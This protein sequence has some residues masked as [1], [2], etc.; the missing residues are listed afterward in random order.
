MITKIA[1]TGMKG[2]D[3]V[4]ELG[5]Y[6]I[7][8]GPNGSGKSART[9]ALQLAVNG[10][11]PG[12]DKKNPDILKAFGTD[13]S[14]I[15]GVETEGHILE[16]HYKTN[17]KGTV[18]QIYKNET[19]ALTKNEFIVALTNA[20]NPRVLNLRA[21]MELSD[22]KKIDMIFKL[23]PPQGDVRKLTDAIEK[24]KDKKNV[25][26]DRKNTAEKVAAKLIADRA[27]LKLPAGTLAE[28][29]N[30]IDK[31]N[32]EL[33][34]ANQH[35]QRLEK[36]EAADE[37]TKQA[38]EKAQREAEEKLEAEIQEK[39]AAKRQEEGE[40]IK[41]TLCDL[42]DT[43]EAPHQGAVSDPDGANKVVAEIKTPDPAKSINAIIKAIQAVGCE[44][45][46]TGTGYLVAKRELKKYEENEKW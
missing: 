45:C 31:I 4:Q 18:T 10:F 40:N 28:T 13:D 42:P 7:F 1:G 3:F 9:D 25:L 16:R 44:I 2:L 17:Q 37:A 41:S 34:L 12:V 27:Q 26:F 19:G 33:N 46:A 35:L 24:C 15:V 22:A 21:F 39:E 20:G 29:T 36:Q 8:I 14:L 43:S 5:K 11:V 32:A 38:E 30:E 6:T 23:Y